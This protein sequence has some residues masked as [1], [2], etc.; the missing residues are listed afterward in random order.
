MTGRVSCFQSA[1]GYLAQIN[2]IISFHLESVRLKVEW[3]CCPLNLPSHDIWLRGDEENSCQLS[4][5]QEEKILVCLVFLVAHASSYSCSVAGLLLVCASLELALVVTPPVFW[6]VVAAP[7]WDKVSFVFWAFLC[8]CG[9]NGSAGSCLL[10]EAAGQASCRSGTQGAACGFFL[11]ITLLITRL[12]LNFIKF[13][14][15]IIV[16]FNNWFEGIWIFQLVWI[17]CR[18]SFSP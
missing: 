17:F 8:A 15:F 18:V 14:V 5:L 4:L 10:A 2:L 13:H 1:V 12:V 11:H 7:G 3:R 9:W 6:S 16:I